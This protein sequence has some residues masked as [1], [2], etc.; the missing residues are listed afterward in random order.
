MNTKTLIVLTLLLS[1]GFGYFVLVYRPQEIKTKC[2][3]IATYYSPRTDPVTREGGGKYGGIL[4]PDGKNIDA[5]VYK[6]CLG[7]DTVQK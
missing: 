3:E 2:L 4:L 1:I 7:Q 6:Q 5:G